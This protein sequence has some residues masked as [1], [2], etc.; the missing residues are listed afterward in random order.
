MITR[1]L[2]HPDSIVVIGGSN[3][4]SK[5]GGKILK[6]IIDGGFLGKLYVS[7]PKETVVQ[8][9][10]S[11]PNPA[12]LPQVDLAVIAIAAKYIPDLVDLLTSQ[13][14]TRAFIILSAGFSEESHAGK[15]LE[16][17]IV[18]SVNKVGGSLIGPNCVGVLTPQHHSIFTYPIPELHPKGCDFISGSGATACFIMEAG[19]PKGLRFANVYS[20]GNSAQMGVEE[21][22]KHMDETFNPET[23]AHV[24]LLYIEHIAKPALLLKHASSLIRKGCRI[25]AIKAGGSDAGSRAASSHTG[26][27]A[28]SDV[29]VEALFRKCGIVRCYGREE[30]IAV[31]SVFMH[32]LLEGKRIAII[33]HAGGPAVMLTDALSNGGLEIPPI[34]GEAAEILKE[35]LFPG[36]SVANP[37]DFLA[38]GTAEQL[39]FIIDAVDNEF[40]EIDAM[41]VIFGTPGLNEIFDVYALLDQK[42]NQS[43]KPIFPV[44]PSTLTAKK[45]VE[46]FLS[47]GHVNFPDEVMLGQALSR[48]MKTGAPTAVKPLLPAIDKATIRKVIDQVSDG[49]ISPAAIQQLLDAAG[50]VRA[51]E[52]VVT[53]VGEAVEQA[54]KLGYPIVMKVVGPVHKSDVGGVVLGVDTP[55]KVAYEFNRMMAIKDTTAILMQPMLRGT[56][57]FA[58]AKKEGNFGHL[59]LCGLGGIFIEVLKDV[60]SAISPV[61]H[62]EA[63]SMIRSLKSYALIKGVRGQKGI[64]EQ[65]FCDAITRLSALLEAAPEISELDLNPLLGTADAVIAVDARIRIEKA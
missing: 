30:L 46:W 4:T 19:I 10:T 65:A 27:L 49:Y 59:V 5:P 56:E 39:G 2:T 1:Q 9:I 45:E 18:A 33:T 53:Q 62:D 38:T 58:G 57:L 7:N 64:N 40:H 43:K 42:M 47:R 25:A 34:Q 32:P 52:T 37:I 13:K 50:I 20:V 48:V 22:L 41:I 11:Y 14:N 16:E 8:G 29:A 63:L 17:R 28:S 51:G 35:K 21:V 6:N 54:S 15:L 36:S 26:A 12:D 31:A 60:S 3:D 55:D 61:G 23:D 44:L 24:K